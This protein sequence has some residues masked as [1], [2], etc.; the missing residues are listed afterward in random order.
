MRPLGIKALPPEE[1][2]RGG[3][4]V[5]AM[6][7]TVLR[8]GHRPARDKRLSTHLMLA[9]RAFGASEAFYCGT[10]DPGLE[11]SVNKIVRDWGGGFKVAYAASWRKVMSGWGGRIVHL[12]MY[13]LPA[14]EAVPLVRAADGPLLVV[15]GGPKVP[16]EVYDTAD[17]NV[18][19]TG[20]P[21][22]EV[23]A[24]A[25]FLHMLQEGSELGLVFPGARLR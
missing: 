15:V 9:A 20:Q 19:V 3:G 13:G 10:E 16:R 6:R 22:S 23:S 8:L 5:T 2:I 1:V 4:G 18:S 24:L 17:W 25:V 11:E 14:R 21:H 12:T 7:I